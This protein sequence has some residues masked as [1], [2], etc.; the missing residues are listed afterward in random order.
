MRGWW[1]T[2]GCNLWFKT[3]GVYTVDD[4]ELYLLLSSLIDTEDIRLE[5]SALA[6]V[7]GPVRLFKEPAGQK[8][9]EANNLKHKTSNATHIAWATGGSMVPA[10]V[11][12]SYYKKGLNIPVTR[13]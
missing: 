8:Y 10:E 1:R 2:G 5:P 4:D 11:M 3:S 7:A 13:K 12:A 6:G 9:L